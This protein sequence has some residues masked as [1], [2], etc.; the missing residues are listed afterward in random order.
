MWRKIIL[1]VYTL[2]LVSLAGCASGSAPVQIASYPKGGEPVPLVGKAIVYEAFFVLEV[3]N[4]SRAA[5][6]V[7]RL[8]YDCNGYVVSDSAA[9]PE[10]GGHARLVIAVPS[11]RYEAARRGLL[12]I[13]DLTSERSLGQAP[14]SGSSASTF[15]R[16]IVDLF[17][18]RVYPYA[19]KP[20]GWNPGRTFEQALAVSVAIFRFGVDALIWLL[21]VAGPFFLMGWGIRRL[22]KKLNAPK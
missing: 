13:G 17:P 10:V 2:A 6:E 3:D 16:L 21:V 1:S 18:K 19:Y 15:S 22:V 20:T 14:P 9:S 5:W 8:A 11:Y 4:L 7:S 12:R